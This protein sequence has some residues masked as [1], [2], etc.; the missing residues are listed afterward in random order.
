[1]FCYITQNWRGRPLTDHATIID[2]I[3]STTTTTGLK[4]KA[5]LDTTTYEKGIKITDA[6]MKRLNIQGEAFHPEWNYSVRPR[7]KS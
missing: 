3:A 7:S 5:V 1:M 6:E 4:V 2:L